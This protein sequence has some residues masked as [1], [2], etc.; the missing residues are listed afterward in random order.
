MPVGSAVSAKDPREP[1]RRK[2]LTPRSV[3]APKARATFRKHERL[4]GRDAINAVVKQ[5]AALNDKPFRLV[6]RIGPL[7]S[8]A[9]AQVAFAIPKRHVKKATDRNYI[10]RLMREAYR[11]E[12]E[13]WY[14]PL[15]AAGVQC[16]WLVIYQ[17]SQPL[18]FTEVR[19]RLCGLMDR[20]LLEYLP[21]T[22]A[23][24]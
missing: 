2:P 9:P 13:R 8:T 24:S 1:Q 6:G 12:K 14:E 10:R 5:G 7:D 19:Q 3:T 17:S 15:R 20:W 16:A 21:K 18:A 22:K 4:T 11:L 23:H